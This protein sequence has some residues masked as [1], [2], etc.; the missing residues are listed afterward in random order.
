MEVYGI[1]YKYKT[2]DSRGRRTR[3]QFIQSREQ[4]LSLPL[5]FGTHDSAKQHIVENYQAEQIDDNV[6]ERADV[7]Y[8]IVVV[9]VL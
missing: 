2:D 8:T 9:P 6:F 5:I 3:E 7:R 4:E 1:T